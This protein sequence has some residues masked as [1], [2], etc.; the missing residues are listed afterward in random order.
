MAITVLSLTI[1]P[2]IAQAEATD[3]ERRANCESTGSNT[4]L[5]LPTWY[6]YLETEY[7]DGSCDVKS[8]PDPNNPGSTDIGATVGAIVFAV[9][10]ILLRIAGIVAV[11]YV[12]YGGILF[13]MSQGQPEQLANARKTL[14]NGVIGLVIAVFAVAIVNLATNIL[15]V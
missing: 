12:I 6:K 9:I 4:F 5:G 3:A 11:G 7:V 2:N 15:L 1:K 13:S 10:E 14:I 8:V